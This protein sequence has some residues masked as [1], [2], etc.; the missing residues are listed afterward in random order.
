MR[1]GCSWLKMTLLALLFVSTGSLLQAQEDTAL[2][3]VKTLPFSATRSTTVPGFNVRAI[4]VWVDNNMAVVSS[5]N[6]VHLVDLSNISAPVSHTIELPD[7]DD[8][9]DVK[10]KDDLLYVGLQSSIDQASLLIYDVRNPAMPVMLNRFRSDEFFATHNLFVA[11]NVVFLVTVKTAL[12][13]GEDEVPPERSNRLW[14]LDV[15]DPSNPKDLGPVMDTLTDMPITRNHDLT[16]IGNRAYIAAWV[17][18]IYIVDFEHLD[19][20][21]NLTYETMMHHQYE[22]AASSFNFP[23]PSTHNLWPSEDGMV[24]WSTDEVVGESIRAFDISDFSNPRLLGQ[25]RISPRSMPHNV[26][27]QGDYAYV[28]HYLDGV[29]VL[30]IGDGG[31]EEVARHDTV[32][33]NARTNPFRGAFGVFPLENHVLVSDTF[34]GLLIFEKQGVLRLP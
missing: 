33:N 19:D 4:D 16:V 14:M 28:S 13:E 17:N 6:L 2:E 23:N 3:R 26:I 29:R 30:Q 5:A 27:V 24:L 1:H 9:W 21:Q 10:L 15:T 34:N 18:G 11:E 22:P 7:G 32:G 12:R 20:P 8:T 25:Y 31:I